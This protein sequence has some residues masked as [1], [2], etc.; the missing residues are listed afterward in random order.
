MGGPWYGAGLPIRWRGWTCL[1]A[2]FSEV[3]L[4]LHLALLLNDNLKGGRIV[5][6]IVVPT[7][8]LVF[9]VRAKTEGRW[10][11]RS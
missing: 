10:R 7:V 5:A 11:W 9:V 4:E 1:A 2:Y 8:V 3:F 6:A